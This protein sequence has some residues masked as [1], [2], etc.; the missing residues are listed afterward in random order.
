MGKFSFNEHLMCDLK[1]GGVKFRT[2]FKLNKGTLTS[3][4]RGGE[5]T[6]LFKISK[7]TIVFHSYLKK[8]DLHAL[9]LKSIIFARQ[10]MK[11]W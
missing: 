5:I 11:T 6:Y 9:T 1:V 4:E 8:N 3:R 2:H 10:R 7:N